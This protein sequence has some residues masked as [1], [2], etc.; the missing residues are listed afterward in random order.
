M[1]NTK[2]KIAIFTTLLITIIA[3]IGWIFYMSEPK[4]IDN[5]KTYR[6]NEIERYD[7]VSSKDNYGNTNLGMVIQIDTNFKNEHRAIVKNLDPVYSWDK[8]TTI[9]LYILHDST[10]ETYGFTADYRIIGKGTFYHKVNTFVGFNIMMITTILIGIVGAI[11][12]YTLT[13]I[14][15]EMLGIRSIWF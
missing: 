4:Y 12:F 9:H 8:I 7:V 15:F 14:L 6:Q 13:G 2:T 11:I 3:Y 1:K 10:S 5:A